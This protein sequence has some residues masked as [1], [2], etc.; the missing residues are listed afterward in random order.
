MT[1]SRLRISIRYKILGV[2]GLLLIAA[3][4]FYTLLASFIFRQEKVALLYDINHSSAV[5]TAAQLRSSLTQTGDE[6]KLFVVAQVLADKTALKLPMS[7]LQEAHVT[8]A[9]LFKKAPKDLAG[10]ELFTETK[11]NVSLPPLDIGQKELLPRLKEADESNYAFWSTTKGSELPRFVLATKV[12]IHLANET[13]FYIAV[14]ELEGR[15]FFQTLQ[16]T[17]LF[18][19]YLVKNNGE[20]LLQCDRTSISSSPAISTHPLLKRA[21]SQ[22]TITSGYLAFDYQGKSWYG[23][24]A[25]VGIG[26]SISSARRAGTLSPWRCKTWSSALSSSASS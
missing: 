1:Q 2:L 7:Y 9:R 22:S 4:C 16:A 26:I 5:N 18:R 25:P 12:E 23:A 21:I 19:S 8:S 13:E 11:L 6:L 10:R 17:N 20:V 15:P 24:Y 3:V 14:A